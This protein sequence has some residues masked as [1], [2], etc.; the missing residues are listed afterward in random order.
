MKTPGY[1]DQPQD[2]ASVTA[3][4]SGAA[5]VQPVSPSL[6]P[7]DEEPPAADDQAE[8]D[9]DV[10]ECPEPGEEAAK[11]PALRDPGEPTLAEAQEHNLTHAAFRS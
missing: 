11:V 8:D 5:P 10:R 4:G 7:L 6:V 2:P 3:A 1:S 9:E